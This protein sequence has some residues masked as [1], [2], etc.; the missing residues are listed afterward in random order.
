MLRFWNR[1]VLT[2]IEGTVGTIYLALGQQAAPG[3]GG[4]RALRTNEEGK[5]E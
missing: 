3:F 2:N 5:V 4:R 1:D